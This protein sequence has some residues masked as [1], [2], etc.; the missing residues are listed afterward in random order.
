MF[1]L[2]F[3]IVLVLAGLCF[4]ASS[5]DDSSS[6]KEASTGAGGGDTGE[7]SGGGAPSVGN[8]DTSVADSAASGHQ[9][10]NEQNDEAAGDR[11]NRTLGHSLPDF[12]G[13]LDKKRQYVTRLQWTCG[14][15]HHTHKINEEL[16][17]FTNCTYT[18]IKLG[19]PL[20]HQEKRI[21]PGMIC[22]VGDTK[23][24]KDGPCPSPA[25]P[26]C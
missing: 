8:G 18:C 19:D 15:Q 23:C 1:K 21:P 26:T 22:N 5:E 24:P 13:N 11:E 14:T 10:D 17:N 7:V 12:V 2:S 20:V 25:L 6:G 3:L 9:E 4:G 16:I